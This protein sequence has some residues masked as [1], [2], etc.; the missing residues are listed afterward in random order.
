MYL[1]YLKFEF[2]EIRPHP[3][4]RISLPLESYRDA[5]AVY[6]RRAALV[7]EKLSCPSHVICTMYL[8]VLVRTFQEILSRNP[9]LVCT[10]MYWYVLV[11]TAGT[12]V[13]TILPV[14]DPVQVYRI[15][16]AYSYIPRCTSVRSEVFIWKPQKV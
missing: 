9:V 14:P 12:A 11:R 10:G 5:V 2:F 3:S 8:Y 1:R 16:D 13:H 6:C 15:P 4:L 7:Y